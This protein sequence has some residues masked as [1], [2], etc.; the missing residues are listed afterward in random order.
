MSYPLDCYTAFLL[1]FCLMSLFIVVTVWFI[2]G[3]GLCTKLPALIE[4]KNWNRHLSHGL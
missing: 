1:M 3:G 2:S 4:I